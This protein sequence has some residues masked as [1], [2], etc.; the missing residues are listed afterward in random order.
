MSNQKKNNPNIQKALLT[1][2]Y[3]PKEIAKVAATLKHFPTDFIVE[4]IA[5]KWNCKVS[6][7]FIPN[8]P[9][10][11]E[12]L[13][14]E[15]QKDFLWLEL[16]KLD[17]DHF[18]AIKELT[19]RLRKGTDAIGYA[20]TKDKS[21]WTSQRISIFTPDLEK[22]KNF[23]HEKIIL[24]NFKWNKRK[25]KL[26][27]LEGNHFKLI[28]RNIDKKDAVKISNN[29]RGLKNF[30]NYFGSQRFGLRE[31]NTEIG[32][33]ILKRNW[34]EAVE[35]ILYKTSPNERQDITDARKRLNEEKNFEEA[36]K[37]FPRNLRLER[38]II[39][40]L[41]RDSDDYLAA[42]KRGERK[43]ILMFIHSVQSKIFNEILETALDEGMDFTKKGQESCLLVG[44]KTRFYDGRLGDIEKAVIKNN[45][46]TLEDFDVKEIPYL[47][48]KG[49]FRK[50]LTII[51]DLSLDIEDDEEFK[52][53]KKI[54]VKFTL[55]SGVYATT[56]LDN[57]FIFS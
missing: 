41:A 21:A 55:P 31:N 50:A 29:I 56:F 12:G 46:L 42:I 35:E 44:Y 6:K 9:T 34:K 2:P 19:N 52:G 38:G 15:S 14:K 24:K 39:S 53:S 5:D 10:N 27:Y 37:Y 30:P 32:K 48:I 43:N 28:L 22:I 40:Q 4:E 16:E 54:I 49:S 47:R 20:G 51:K 25:I 8:E 57:F 13:D 18:T 17:I 45:N 36:L 23:K 11:L 33:L 1:T 7:E 26:G 3:M